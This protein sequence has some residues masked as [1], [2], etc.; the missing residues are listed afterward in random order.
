M[1]ASNAEDGETA[2]LISKQF[3]GASASCLHFWYYMYGSRLGMGTLRVYL[4]RKVKNGSK[5]RQWKLWEKT[6]NRG[7][8]WQNKKITIKKHKKNLAFQVRETSKQ[9]Q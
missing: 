4:Q 7:K 6:R 8:K 5:L 1:D 3:S 9:M 2:K